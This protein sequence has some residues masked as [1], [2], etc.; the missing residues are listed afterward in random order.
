MGRLVIIAAREEPSIFNFIE[1]FRSICK[2]YRYDNGAV[3]RR[4]QRAGDAPEDVA[5]DSTR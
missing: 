1:S 4:A 3:D 2:I 5:W